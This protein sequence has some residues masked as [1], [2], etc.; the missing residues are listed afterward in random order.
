M[1]YMDSKFEFKSNL[2]AGKFGEV[3]LTED[4]TLRAERAVKLIPISKISNQRNFFQEAQILKQ[5]E[6]KNIVQIY[7][8]GIFDAEKIYVSMEILK[9][10]SLQN[11]ASGR[12]VVLTRAKKLM[13]DV[14]RGLQW[15]HSK[16]IIHRD[17]KPSNILIGDSYE[18]KLSDFGL[19]IQNMSDSDLTVTSA[20]EYT[21]HRAP[22]IET[23]V[24]Y[25]ELTDIYACGVT[26]YRLV[27]GDS[28]FIPESTGNVPLLIQSG[29]LPDRTKYR[30]FVP[31]SLRSVI[32]KAMN[33]DPEMRY[34]SAEEF[35]SALERIP[36]CLNW[37]ERRHSNGIIWKT[38]LKDICYEVKLEMS[39]K[40]V[41]LV[42]LRKGPNKGSM[43]VVH[44]ASVDDLTRTNAE[45]IA[46]KLLQDA[47]E[48]KSDLII[49]R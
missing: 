7:E 15:A 22:E 5:A 24:D 38:G 36:I 21:L 32:N 41:Y 27:N 44:K 37:E 18:G 25:N 2:G 34:Q 31:R 19:A 48:G 39:V 11:E 20:Y 13:I 43:R 28:F 40:D 16:G 46:R 14:L 35:R 30:D 42:Q 33:P 8:A 47:V 3:W 12:Y 45:K 6:H 23:P 49:K 4:L 26:L 29:R 17:I 10:G 1:S 9:K